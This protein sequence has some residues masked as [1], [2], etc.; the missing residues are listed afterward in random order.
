MAD[1][2]TFCAKFPPDDYALLEALS[3]HERLRRGDIVR[4]AVRAYAAQ[5]GV[6]ANA[7]AKR[8]SKR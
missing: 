4:R 3:A 6:T 8:K 1:L 7:N 5:L 2:I